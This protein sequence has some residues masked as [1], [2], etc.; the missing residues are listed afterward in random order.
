MTTQADTSVYNK[1][2]FLLNVYL[3]TLGIV[4]VYLISFIFH[5]VTPIRQGIML[6]CFVMV[7]IGYV[8]L[9]QSTTITFAAHYYVSICFA[10]IALNSI[11]RGG[12]AAPGMI[13]FMMC[14]MVSFLTI[15][16]SAARVWLAIVLTTMFA[17]Y[18]FDSWIVMDEFTGTKLWNLMAYTLFLIAL[19]FMLRA[20]R[21]KVISRAV[22]LLRVNALLEEKQSLLEASQQQL[23]LNQIRLE[24]AH[25]VE[26]ERSKKL[27]YYLNQHLE[28]SR[29]EEL[30]TG[31][32]QFAIQVIQRFLLKAIDVDSV[33]IW[34][35]HPDSG[36]LK[37]IGSQGK[38][39]SNK[40]EVNT[41]SRTSFPDAFEMLESG[42]IIMS[43]G[44]LPAANQLAAQMKY[45][46]GDSLSVVGCPF[47]I[48]GKFGGFF[49]CKSTSRTWVEEDIIFIRAVSDT[50][51]LA[52]K[53]HQRKMHQRQLEEKQRQIEEANER[54]EQRIADRTA[55]LNH[56]NSKL[57]SIAFTNAHVIRGP[58]CRLVGLSN[59]LNI[60]TDASEQRQIISYMGAS[61]DELNAITI[62]TSEELN[63]IAPR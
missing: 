27:R 55:A 13:W 58:I 20:F 44:E 52:F 12:V 43:P 29:M 42:A 5:D 38:Y 24:K 50:F 49:V 56:I 19:Y 34:Y 60:I 33:A 2:S 9:L 21:M 25:A 35:L 46:P 53:S 51:A 30:H 36:D 28:M 22:E 59:L 14:P 11:T 32:F 17:F 10:G 1:R 15:S 48:E 47:F 62:Q 61:I 63:G 31:S 16:F 37:L 23:A 41:L 39:S 6:G 54:L 8:V 45:Q 26:E 18:F 40:Y 57:T 7:S 4:L 3:I